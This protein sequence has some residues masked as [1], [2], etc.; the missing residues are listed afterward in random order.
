M[1]PQV[2]SFKSALVR[3]AD[4]SNILT[5]AAQHLS[6]G[7]R[8]EDLIV[9]LM[10]DEKGHL[11]S[12]L[13]EGLRDGSTKAKIYNQRILSSL[14]N[15]CAKE[16]YLDVLTVSRYLDGCLDR[17]LD[18][19]SPAHARVPPPYI[20]FR[21]IKVQFAATFPRNIG[22]P[23]DTPTVLAFQ[24]FLEGPDNPWR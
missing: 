18:M 2:N 20:F 12:D 24:K 19:Q 5:Q 9:S 4:Y 7:D 13:V 8:S 11:A 14:K 23:A 15:A 3:I 6:A 10:R 22:D 1:K 17:F 21:P 16:A